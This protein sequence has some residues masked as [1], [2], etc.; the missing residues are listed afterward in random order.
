MQRAYS[1]VVHLAR[2]PLYFWHIP[3]TAGTSLIEW[4]DEKFL[5]EEVF[6]PQLLPQLRGASD[7]EVRGRRL[8]RGHLGSE[9]LTRLDQPIEMVTVMREPRARTI[10]HLGH[11]W[12]HETH[13]LHDRLRAVG[14]DVLTALHDP[15]L[16]RALTDVQSRYLAL[17]PDRT[18]SDPLPLSVTAPLECQARFELAPLPGARVLAGRAVRQLCRMRAIGVTERLDVFARRVAAARGW[19]MS[20]PLPRSNAAPRTEVSWRLADLTKQELRALDAVNRADH[21]L[22]RIAASSRGPLTRWRSSR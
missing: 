7:A 15:L 5:P 19:P 8:Y 4:L 17:A 16:R 22:Y 14:P 2:R 12:R 3:K 11:I 18:K 9:L 20:D 10:S 1:A 6:T 21:L 13:Y